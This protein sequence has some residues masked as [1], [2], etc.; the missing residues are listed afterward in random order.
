MGLRG[1]AAA[2]VAGGWGDN[3][4]QRVEGLSEELLIGLR[5]I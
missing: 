2:V 1:R 3:L 5:S 4:Q